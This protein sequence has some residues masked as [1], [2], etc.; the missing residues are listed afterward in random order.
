MRKGLP[1][2]TVNIILCLMYS[3]FVIGYGSYARNKVKEAVKEHAGVIAGSL[4]DIDPQAPS[5]YINA[6]MRQYDYKSIVVSDNEGTIFI[7]REAQDHHWFEL[8]LINMKLIPRI[9]VSSDIFYEGNV[10][11]KVT[12]VWYCKTLYLYLYVLLVLSLLLVILQLYNRILKEKQMLQHRIEESTA[13]LRITNEGLM[14]SEERFRTLVSNIPGIVYRCA[15][16]LN[17]TIQYMSDEV[18]VLSG[19]PASDFLD[20]AVR[21]F[22]SIIHPDDRKKLE[23]VVSESVAGSRPFTLEYRILHKNGDVRWVYERGQA[24]K[25][26]SGEVL[27]LDGAIFDVTGRKQAEEA[28]RESEQKFKAIFNQTF[29]LSGLLTVD[30]M[31]LALNRTA[32]DFYGIDES[33]ML[34]KPFWETPWWT[35]SKKEQMRLREIIKDAAGGKLVRFETNHI[36]PDGE[37]R[38]FAAS[39]KPIK[40]E[41]GKV[42]MLIPEGRDITDIK[43]AEIALKKERDFSNILVQSSPAFFVAIDRDG[44]TIMM[45]NAMLETLGY[46]LDEVKGKDYIKKFVPQADWPAVK[47][48]FV[49]LTKCVGHTLNENKILTRDGRELLT[50]WHG[51]SLCNA[52]DELD[53]FFGV[54]MDITERRKVEAELEEHREHLKEL[55]RKRT[56]ELEAVNTELKDFA[57]VVSHDLKAPLRAMSQL[58]GWLSQDYA[59]ALDDEGKK[60]VDMLAGR[61]KRMHALVDGI[62]QYSKVGRT[63]EKRGKINL[64]NLLKEV[65]DMVAPPETVQVTIEHE[66][67]VL[68]GEKTRLEQLFQNLLSNAVKFMDK[69]GG[70]IKIF[71][72]D[73]GQYWRF[74]VS[75]NGPG[76]EEK[77]FEKIFQLFQTLT[78]RDQFESTGIGLSLVKRIVEL[79]G[80]KVWVESKMGQGSTFFFTL[81]KREERDED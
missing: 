67:P 32:L 7:E 76:I 36:A 38:F 79:Y 68:V 73:E 6:I 40:N 16:D 43:Q 45:N 44:K 52:N 41:A 20:N 11:G 37:I 34:G 47:E 14:E 51:Q 80:G 24:T 9:P 78:P 33:D 18:K 15:F 69:S 29:Q 35:H 1:L 61:A 49:T 8:F 5:E 59:E 42:I 81:P 26:K 70:E 64:N 57:Y 23:D 17:W 66:L 58:A 65:I 53:F 27:W 60:M 21:S 54:G 50:E 4:W 77:Y 31:V 56:E 2:K 72:A 74:S 39:I 55:V 10:I 30:G 75:D 3:I 25:D 62:L 22:A 12:I 19:Y 71:C 48:Q 46:T 28:L 63:G 13:K